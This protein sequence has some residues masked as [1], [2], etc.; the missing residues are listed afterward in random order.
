M[1]LP[2]SAL[3]PDGRS[4]PTVLDTTHPKRPYLELAN[5]TGSHL[6]PQEPAVLQYQFRHT[7]GAG[8]AGVDQEAF[9]AYPVS[10]QVEV[11]Q[12][13]HPRAWSAG[14]AAASGGWERADGL[15][16]R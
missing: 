14:E 6:Y 2:T 16:A 10:G 8:H 9:R 7:S 4:T 12:A 3:P 5:R 13:W 1:D 11:V 15:D